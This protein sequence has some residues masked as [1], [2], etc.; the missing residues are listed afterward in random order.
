MRLQR[1]FSSSHRRS[2]LGQRN[3]A[4]S[5]GLT[6]WIPPLVERSGKQL[7]ITN[8]SRQL[9][10]WGKNGQKCPKCSKAQ[11]PSI[12]LKIDL[13]VWYKLNAEKSKLKE[14]MFYIMRLN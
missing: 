14:A 1:T 9:S 5:I 6:T 4:D 10:Q 3:S 8:W 12:W 2:S 7:R 13:K 11:G